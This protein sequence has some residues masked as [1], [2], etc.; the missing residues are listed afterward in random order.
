MSYL[1]TSLAVDSQQYQAERYLLGK[2]A[3][4]LATP[5]E[6][7]AMLRVLARPNGLYTDLQRALRD[8]GEW[9]VAM[10]PLA[11]PTPTVIRFY[12]AKLLGGPP[13]ELQVENQRIEEPL[14][15]FYEWSNLDAQRALMGRQLAM[16]GDAFYKVVLK[17]DTAGNAKSVYFE[18][19]DPATV[20][21]FDVDERGFVT[22]IRI[23]I[24]RQER[25]PDGTLSNFVHVEVWS[26][27]DGTY[28]RWNYDQR[29]GSIGLLA[30][31]NLDQLGTPDEEIPLAQMGID[32]VPVV[33]VPFDRQDDD[34]YGMAAVW[35]QI[36]KLVEL[37]LLVTELH[38]KMFGYGRPD[39]VLH[40]PGDNPQGNPKP[41]PD[42]EEIQSV[43]GKDALVIGREKVYSLP[44]GWDLKY[45]VADLDW[46]NARQ[47]A[48]DHYQRLERALPE[49]LYG[50][51]IELGGDISGRALRMMM[52]PAIDRVLEVRA[53]IEH[54]LERAG[55][56]ALT[57]GAFA[58]L[59]KNLGGDFDSGA[60]EHSFVERDVLPLSDLE[61]AEAEQMR[62][63]A[64][65]TAT[66][67]TVP[68]S[69]A[70]E[71]VYG[72]TEEQQTAMLEMMTAQV[73]AQNSAPVETLQ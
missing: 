37:D 3:L 33:H 23:E 51:L 46:T 5:A 35:D 19:L 53:N 48:L 15:K 63:Q 13:L 29:R 39:L 4:R 32:F 11:Q 57:I 68:V 10:K 17:R 36:E 21:D 55:M 9:Q 69:M 27:P 34:K 66:G 16:L 24:P 41:P 22:W 30:P 50:R 14:S 8:D 71:R 64:F 7:Y 58:G 73:E 59:F 1:Q 49:L 54:G 62:A 44:G 26:K 38:S 40:S 2:R 72:M 18:V 47:L 31:D 45:L 12:G 70:L 28:R 61:E 67:S 20:R 25:Q 60:F 52:I 43:N 6:R 65:T 42:L 56:M